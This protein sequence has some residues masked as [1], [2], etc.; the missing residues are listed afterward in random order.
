MYI[1]KATQ[2]WERT[3]S[4]TYSYYL[5]I[6]LWRYNPFRTLASLIRRLHSSLFA[7]FLL[8][9]LIPSSCSASLWTTSAHL[10][11]GLP[12]GLV[13]WTYSYH[14]SLK[15]WRRAAPPQNTLDMP[16]E[17]VSDWF[18]KV[19]IGSSNTRF[20]NFASAH[21]SGWTGEQSHLY[22]QSS[23]CYL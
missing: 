13:V 18:H 20:C 19:Y 15:G 17:H 2:W 11:L 10:V 7:A 21:V 8:H 23:T 6:H 3:V 5:S 4:E 16:C 1:E 9:P 14:C 22:R 12:T